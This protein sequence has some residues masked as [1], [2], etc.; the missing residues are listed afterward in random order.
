QVRALHGLSNAAYCV[1]YSRDGKRLA[2]V[3]SI[4]PGS[5][6]DVAG[7]LW[8]VQTSQK[9]FTIDHIVSIN[10]VAFSPDG[11]LLASSSGDPSGL[12]RAQLKIWDVQSGQPLLNLHG[13]TGAVWCVAFSSDGRRLAS[14]SADA[15]VKLWDVQTGQEVLTLRGH[16]SSVRGVAFSPD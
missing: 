3:G 11:R 16:S 2:A 7:A 14:G 8:D 13:H 12:T 10:G 4:P 5:E 6:S 1:A 9:R 15:T